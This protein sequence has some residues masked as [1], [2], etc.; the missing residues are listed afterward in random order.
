[1]VSYRSSKFKLTFY[2]GIVDVVS[3][4][5]K[6]TPDKAERNHLLHCSSPSGIPAVIVGLI[7][8]IRPSTF[9]MSKVLTTD[10]T[11]GALNLTAEVKRT[12]C[13]TGFTLV[14]VKEARYSQEVTVNLVQLP[15]YWTRKFAI[16]PQ[17][18]S[19]TRVQRVDSDIW[20]SC[21]PAVDELCVGK[22]R[23][24]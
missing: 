15:K 10:V 2:I 11:C 7:A 13:G 18:L 9:D 16:A 24:I 19:T 17:Y 5:Q 6:P 23:S 14:R 21:F 20:I 1:M 8:A 4:A 12:R 3:G 22:T